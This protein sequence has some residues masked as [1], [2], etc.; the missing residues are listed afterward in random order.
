[1]RKAHEEL[2]EVV[3]PHR[4]PDHNDRDSLVYVTA[5]VLEALRWHVV[6]PMGTPHTTIADQEF[7]GY[8]IPA[9][10]A[11]VPG[12]WCVFERNIC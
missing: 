12:T 2:D 3:G 5:I 4:L 8:F 11:I 9:G 10:T 1:M 7:R 6:I